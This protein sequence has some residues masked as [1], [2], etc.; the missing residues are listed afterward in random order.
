MNIIP[1]KVIRQLFLLMLILLVSILIFR[2]ITPYLSGVLGA[3]TIYVL[4][5]KTMTKLVKRGWSPNLAAITLM[6]MSFFTILLPIAGAA[7]MLG[8]KISRA[9]ENSERVTKIVK[10]QLTEI[11][12]RFGYDLTSQI[13][14]SAISGWLSDNLQS[15]AGSTFNTVIAI[16]IMYFMLFYMFTNRKQLRESLMDYIPINRDNL[17]IVGNEMHAMVRANALGIPLVA[18]AQGIVALIG[19]LIFG[20]ESPFFWAVIVTIGSMVPFVGNMLGTLPV[21][22]I[23]MA[24]GNTFEAWGILIYGIVVVGSTDNLI[25]L[26]VLR[27]LD[28]VHPLIT[29]IGVIIGIPLFGFIGL[30]FGPLLISLALVIIRIYKKEYANQKENA[31]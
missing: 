10:T 17:K 6:L 12:T 20:I 7:V 29:L 18:I 24:S 22:I 28:D 3:I 16:S 13:D 31:L 21:F 26:F 23:T 27:K 2:E 8:N 11:E 9:V 5:R 19:F 14:A 25:R 4:L 15:F 30:I 1:P